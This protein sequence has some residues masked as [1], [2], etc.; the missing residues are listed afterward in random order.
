M[1]WRT[2][3]SHCSLSIYPH[4]RP[5]TLEPNFVHRE[6]ASLRTHIDIIPRTAKAQNSWDVF[7]GEYFTPKIEKIGPH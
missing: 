6:I 5:L 2:N 7:E 4:F 1:L 3:A